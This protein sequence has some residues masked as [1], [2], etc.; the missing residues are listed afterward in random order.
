MEEIR[1]MENAKGIKSNNCSSR[2]TSDT[3]NGK[4]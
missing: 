3:P 2:L 1:T 4:I